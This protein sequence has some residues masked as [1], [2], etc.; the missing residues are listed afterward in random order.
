[1]L[2]GPQNLFVM[3]FLLNYFILFRTWEKCWK[4]ISLLM[5]KITNHAQTAVVSKLFWLMQWNGSLLAARQAGWNVFPDPD[6]YYSTPLDVVSIWQGNLW[7]CEVSLRVIGIIIIDSLLIYINN[8]GNG[9]RKAFENSI[10]LSLYTPYRI[11]V[12]TQGNCMV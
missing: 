2:H 3:I 9:N 10:L 1:M 8:I 5:F 4:K 11:S 6:H 7:T 12:A